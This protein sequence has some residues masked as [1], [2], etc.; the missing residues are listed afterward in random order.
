MLAKVCSQIP[1]A[2]A[3][4]IAQPRHER[5]QRADRAVRRRQPIAP[6][7]AFAVHAQRYSVKQHAGRGSPDVA[8][9]VGDVAHLDLASP[10][11]KR[12]RRDR[13]LAGSKMKLSGTSKVSCT[14]CGIEQQLEAR[15]AR[16]RPPG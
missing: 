4:G 12:R 6:G 9:A 14:S 8:L 2:A 11:P 10:L 5:E 7:V 3:V 16:T 1:R 13:W 15:A